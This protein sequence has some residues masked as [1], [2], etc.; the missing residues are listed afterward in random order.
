MACEL[1]YVAEDALYERE[2]RK[3]QDYVCWGAVAVEVHDQ[4]RS[5]CRD[6]NSQSLVHD[7]RCRRDG[8]QGRQGS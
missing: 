8:H 1:L 4:R 3:H 7:A 6:G 5:Q 2:R